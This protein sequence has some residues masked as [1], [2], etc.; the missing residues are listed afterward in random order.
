M[1]MMIARTIES[2][3][4]KKTNTERKKLGIVTYVEREIA[5]RALKYIY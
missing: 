2:K 5:R 4:K 1:I 3:K